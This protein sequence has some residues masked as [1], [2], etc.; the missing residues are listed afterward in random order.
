MSYV[1]WNGPDYISV[2]HESCGH[3]GTHLDGTWREDEAYTLHPSLETSS[4]FAEE[5]GHAAKRCRC[6][7]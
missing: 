1:T 2:H 3:L 4:Q 6:I 5:T 7:D